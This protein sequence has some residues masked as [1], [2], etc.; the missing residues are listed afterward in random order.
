MTINPPEFVKNDPKKGLKVDKNVQ[1]P[2][3]YAEILPPG[4]HQFMIYDP[5]TDMMWFKEFI[6]DANTKDTYPESPRNFY[7]VQKP[8][9]VD[10]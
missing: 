2:F 6:L 9:L 4:H 10:L 5:Q 8:N 7:S 1:V 3:V